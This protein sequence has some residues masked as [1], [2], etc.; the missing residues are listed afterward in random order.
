MFKADSPR[1]KKINE[2]LTRGVEEIF[3]RD[4]LTK[5]ITS[6]RILRIKLGI[7]PTGPKI[8]IGRATILRKLKAFQDLGHIAVLIVGDFTA[9][10]GDPSDKLE[11]RPQLTKEEIEENL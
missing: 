2:V 6:D 9:S 3:T 1:E 4:S 11:K 8:H 10:I 7:D 5:K